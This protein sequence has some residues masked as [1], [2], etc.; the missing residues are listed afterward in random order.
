MFFLRTLCR[1]E[2]DFGED[3]LRLDLVKEDEQGSALGKR[4]SLVLEL[5]AVAHLCHEPCSDTSQG[6]EKSGTKIIF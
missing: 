3:H 1:G 4:A 6:G 5:Q 2:G